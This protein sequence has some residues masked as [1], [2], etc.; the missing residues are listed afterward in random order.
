MITASLAVTVD[1][2]MNRRTFLST[3]AAGVAG[4]TMGTAFGEATKGGNTM[5][6][7]NLIKQNMSLYKKNL[8][9]L[10]RIPSISAEEKHRQDLHRVVDK[11]SEFARDLGYAT[12]KVGETFPLFVAQL[13][14]DD[15][16]PWLL[17]YNHLDV[18]PADEASFVPDV[19]ESKI[20]GR[21]TTDDKG[22]FLATL[23]AIALLYQQ[24][25]LPVNVAFAVETE[26]EI[27]G[28]HFRE[29]IEQARWK[30]YI[31]TPSSILLSDTT[32]EGDNPVLTKG[33]R[34]LIKAR[35]SL[36]LHGDNV[37]SGLAGGVARSPLGILSAAINR[38]YDSLTGEIF[39]PHFHDGTQLP[40][41]KELEELQAYAQTISLQQQLADLKIGEAFTHDPLEALLRVWYKGTFEVHDFSGVQGTKIPGE[42]YVDVTMRLGYGMNGENIIKNFTA[43]LQQYHPAIQVEASQTPAFRADTSHYYF[44]NAAAA[45]R[46]GYGKEPVMALSG[47]TIGA[48]P[49]L[50]ELF[51]SVPIVEIAMSKVSDGYHAL[52][53]QFEWKQAEM[54]MKTM[55]YYVRSVKP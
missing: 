40:Q 22:P 38:C 51:P 6:I 9:A 52:H 29:R 36:K 4:L 35:A 11:A 27:S 5:N 24:G 37:H 53:E 23:T 3:A 30:G 16:L 50:Q 1:D 14:V 54:G 45:C 13:K 8:A 32:F 7:E 17:V 44:A 31:P 21:G 55:A 19:S 46:K 41:G 18:Q 43:L 48:L 2:T 47:G 10:V 25:M 49:I 34:G 15:K 12:S 28:Q 26:E 42:A 33:T 20:V 39:I